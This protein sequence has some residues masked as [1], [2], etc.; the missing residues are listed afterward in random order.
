MNSRQ[1]HIKSR[2]FEKIWERVVCPVRD[3]VLRECDDVFV[4]STGLHLVEEKAWKD[5]IEAT[6]RRLRKECKKYCYGNGKDLGYL[7]SRKIAA[8]F[9]KAIIQKKA[10]SF[11]LDV[12]Q[13]QLK[14][15]R[16]DRKYTN[17]WIVDN[18]LVNYKLAY[19]VS[20]QLLYLT[21]LEDLL[22]REE[23]IDDAFLLSEMRHLSKYPRSEGYDSFDINMII[24]LAQSDIRGNDFDMLLFSM[25][26]YQIE[27]YTRS[28]LKYLLTTSSDSKQ[29][30]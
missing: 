15:S 28:Q 29:T 21:L 10:F 13:K 3:V 26:L 5:S 24:Y 1:P 22:Y 7:D 4:Q 19:L 17:R 8:I 9:C 18:I 20:L 12:A 14:K 16:L 27:M 11:D 2:H 23:T 30:Q 25:Q 6:Y